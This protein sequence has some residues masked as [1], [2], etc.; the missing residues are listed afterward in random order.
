MGDRYGGLLW[1]LTMGDHYGTLSPLWG[2]IMG[3]HYGL[4]SLD[5]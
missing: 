3:P 1:D 5:M 4:I 2:T